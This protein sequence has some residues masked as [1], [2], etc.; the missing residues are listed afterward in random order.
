M[1]GSSRSARRALHD[2]RQALPGLGLRARGVDRA[3]CSRSICAPDRVDVGD[4]SLAQAPHHTRQHDG[5]GLVGR[6]EE[7]LTEPAAR[8]GDA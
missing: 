2:L 1:S 4:A 6:G 7:H 3:C 5:P 8:K